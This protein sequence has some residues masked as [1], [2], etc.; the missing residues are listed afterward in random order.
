ML[1][2]LCGCDNNFSDVFTDS[3]TEEEETCDDDTT[4]VSFKKVAYWSPDDSDNLEDVDFDALTHIIYASISVSA[5]GSLE[6]LDDADEDLLQELV[7]YADAAGIKVGISLGDGDDNNF[8]TIAES[9]SITNDFVNEVDDFV[10]DYDLDG[11]DINWQT[12]DDDD[13]SDNLEELLEEL[14]EALSEDSRFL[15]MTVTSGED[16]SQADEVDNDLFDY[17]DFVNVMAFDSTDSDDLHSSLEDAED[18]ITYW[19]GRCLIQN[20]LVLGV[21]FYSQ[22]DDEDVDET[23]SYDYI[24]DDDTDYAC[25]DESEGR[26]YNGIPTIMDKT[27]YALLYAGGVMIK[28]LEQDSYENPDY[29][30]LD[31]INETSD[32]EYV[33]ICD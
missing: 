6:E 25:V 33:D 11:V 32:G 22:D 16:D 21:P 20:K 14:E 23:L 18:A 27:N 7:D 3:W 24:V 8:N 26:N 4:S 5:N 1:I 30:L 19:T 31:V 2:T 17:V 15:S 9:S 28:S 12:I 13:E 29:L 10:E